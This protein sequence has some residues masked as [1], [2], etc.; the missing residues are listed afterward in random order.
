MSCKS[1]KFLSTSRDHLNE[2]LKS[3]PASDFNTCT[4][5]TEKP[6]ELYFTST[7]LFYVK[8]NDCVCG[9]KNYKPKMLQLKLF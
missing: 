6:E 5:H 1:C 8:G 9:G 3:L 7:W 2:Y 4:V